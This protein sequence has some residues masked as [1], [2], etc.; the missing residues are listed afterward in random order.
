MMGPKKL[1]EIREELKTAIAKTG[2][3]PVSWL[4]AELQRLRTRRPKVDPKELEN[5]LAVRDA[6]ATVQRTRPR[7]SKRS[8]VQ[9]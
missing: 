7:R 4:E 5:L 6:L 2:D 9:S 3:D 1:S 8:R